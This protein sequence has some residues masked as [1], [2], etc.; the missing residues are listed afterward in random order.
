MTAKMQDVRLEPE[1]IVFVPSSTGKNVG[2][3]TLDGIVRVATGLAVRG[4][5]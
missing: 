4:T 1:D 2:L 3:K 5:Y